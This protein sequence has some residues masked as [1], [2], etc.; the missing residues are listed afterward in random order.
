MLFRSGLDPNKP[1]TPEPATE[2]AMM[3]MPDD[4]GPNAEPPREPVVGPLVRKPNEGW[5]KLLRLFT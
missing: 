4:P 5:N 3:R 1:A 2:Q